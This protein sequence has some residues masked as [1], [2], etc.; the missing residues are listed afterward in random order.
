MHRF[1]NLELLLD[2]LED[3]PASVPDLLQINVMADAPGSTIE[4]KNLWA[5]VKIQNVITVT[6]A[7]I[8]GSTIRSMV[9]VG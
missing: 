2:E 1:T 6:L 3:D 8:A 9:G 4:E 7:D 5:A